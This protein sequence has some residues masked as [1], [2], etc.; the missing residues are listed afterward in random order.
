VES[1]A[2]VLTTKIAWTSSVLNV[3]GTSQFFEPEGED[4]FGLNNVFGEFI[5]AG[6]IDTPFVGR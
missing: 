4:I 2:P 5:N 1:V 6:T 3:A